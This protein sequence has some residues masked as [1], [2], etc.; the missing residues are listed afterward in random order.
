VTSVDGNGL[1]DDNHGYNF[2]LNA[3]AVA[4]IMVSVFRRQPF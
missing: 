1:I 3:K 4:A 2:D